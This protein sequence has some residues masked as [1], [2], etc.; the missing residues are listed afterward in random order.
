MIVEAGREIP[1]GSLIAFASVLGC[2]HRQEVMGVL[3]VVGVVAPPVRTPLPRA[4]VVGILQGDNV[5]DVER[6]CLSKRLA[7][8][9]VTPEASHYFAI[10]RSLESY[11]IFSRLPN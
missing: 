7:G 9:R 8:I 11:G 1:V 2:L 4:R 3:K 6:A 5:I 10:A